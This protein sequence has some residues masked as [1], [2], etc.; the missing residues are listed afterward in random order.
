MNFG[1]LLPVALLGLTV[2][3]AA[4]GRTEDR[5]T[6]TQVAATV[7]GDE[8]S[9]HQV[10]GAIARMGDLA[11]QDMKQAGARVLERYIDQELLVQKAM[12]AKL[13][14]DPQ[15]MRSME[16]A[17]R[18]ILAQAYLEKATGEALRISAAESKE[19]YQRNPALFAKRRIYRVQELSV[20]MSRDRTTDLEAAVAKARNLNDI[21][22]WL[23]AQR[24][25]F[26]IASATR[27][28]EHVPLNLLQKL[29]DMKDG[30]ITMLPTPQG[31]SIVQRVQSQAAPL[32]EEQA[33]PVIERFLLNRK[34]L[35][36]AESEVKRLRAGARIRYVGEFAAAHYGAATPAAAPASSAGG[37][38]GAQ[39][40]IARDLAGLK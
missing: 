4:C 32:T 12:E 9:V 28:A 13:D 40:W 25:P 6:P 19:F 17:K 3:L 33:G 1:T 2:A 14:R 20:A 21:V 27:P 15:V 10:T 11:P 36:L 29:M 18:Q 7:N 8:I 16:S 34:R 26:H 30:E 23:K 38:A 31:A 39:K 37:S 35:A 22:R 24:L 5:K